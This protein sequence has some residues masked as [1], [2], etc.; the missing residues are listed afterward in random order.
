MTQK[1]ESPSTAIKNDTGRVIEEPKATDRWGQPRCRPERN[2]VESN[3]SIQI[4]RQRS[5]FIPKLHTLKT[6]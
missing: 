2:E 3:G 1:N 4:T 5:T 6:V